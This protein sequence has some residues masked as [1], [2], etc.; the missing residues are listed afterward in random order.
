[1]VEVREISG[2]E[3]ESYRQV[4]DQH[5]SLFADPAWA[6]CFGANVRL[7]GIFTGN[8][9]LTGGFLYAKSSMK[10]YPYFTNLPFTPSIALFYINAA[11]NPSNRLGTDKEILEAV[12]TFFSR[13]RLPVQRF[14]LPPMVKDMQPFFWKGFKVIPHLTYRVDLKRPETDL[15]A[16]LSAKLRNNIKKAKSDGITVRRIT[17]YSECEPMILNTYSR[18]GIGVDYEYIRNIIHRFATPDN[19]FAFGS[20]QD[21]VLIATSFFLHDK[22]TAYYLLGGFHDT[23]K[24]EGAGAWSIWEGITTAKSKGL[25]VFDFE[26]SMIPR[27]EKYFRGFGGDLVSYLTINRAPFLV[28]MMLKLFKRSLF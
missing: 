23:L 18:N 25:M 17:D 6:Q 12:A 7:C 1:M 15:Y 16:N 26:G 27:I 10:G 9:V 22:N 19:S 5:G 3:I 2:N 28:E 14:C 20:F 4:C 21:E 24:H 13:F 11:E 8:N